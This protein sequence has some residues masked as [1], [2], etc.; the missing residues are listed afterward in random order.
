MNVTNTTTLRPNQVALDNASERHVT[1]DDG[2]R[3]D[4]ELYRDYSY[5]QAAALRRQAVAERRACF[6]AA[7]RKAAMSCVQ[8]LRGLLSA[9]RP[10]A[11]SSVG[12]RSIG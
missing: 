9:P 3:L 11:G 2:R 12:S 7:L 4:L 5:E 8:W 1:C 10:G 6:H